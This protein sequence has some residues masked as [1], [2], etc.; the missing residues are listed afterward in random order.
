MG[1]VGRLAERAERDA[2]DAD[3][4]QPPKHRADVVRR[5]ARAERVD[6][7]RVSLILI[8]GDDAP[9]AHVDSRAAARGGG[10]WTCTWIMPYVSLT[11]M[12]VA[13]KGRRSGKS[14][15][16]GQGGGCPPPRSGPAAQKRAGGFVL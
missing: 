13:T 1:V 14:A 4:T 9:C 12:V 15:T 3:L 11:H 8:L 10:V 5:R 2:G 16:Y 7:P 6:L